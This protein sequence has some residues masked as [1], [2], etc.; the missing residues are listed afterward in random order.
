M[1]LLSEEN[2]SITF[3]FYQFGLQPCLLRG[4]FDITIH[5]DLYG[6]LI[7]TCTQSFYGVVVWP[8]LIKGGVGEVTH[9][10][11]MK[12]GVSYIRYIKILLVLK[13]FVHFHT[14]I[15]IVKHANNFMV[16]RP[17]TCLNKCCDMNSFEYN[18]H[19][20]FL[21]FGNGNSLFW[22]QKHGI[23]KILSRISTLLERGIED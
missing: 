13:H 5:M 12:G 22:K 17:L 15:I 9:I 2:N 16:K 6:S 19:C 23:K 7:A 3:C 14:S 1:P 11:Y 4:T 21:L 20:I 10:Q 8:V 18:N